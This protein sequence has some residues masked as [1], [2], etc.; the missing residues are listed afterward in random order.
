[1]SSF[2]RVERTDGAIH[3]AIA[4]EQ[5]GTV[6]AGSDPGWAHASTDMV[7]TGMA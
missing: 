2:G 6:F 4:I 1:M 7:S 5:Q 3:S